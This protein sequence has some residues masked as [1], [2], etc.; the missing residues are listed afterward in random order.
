M[1]EIVTDLGIYF[2]FLVL[3]VAGVITS[4]KVAKLE[5]RVK[6]LEQ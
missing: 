5:A 3:A 4:M 2:A 6:R 1:S